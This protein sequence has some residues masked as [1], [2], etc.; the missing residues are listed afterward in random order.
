MIIRYLLSVLSS[1]AQSRL[2]SVHLDCATNDVFI[3]FEII[4]Y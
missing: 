3:K 1:R 4:V 2:G